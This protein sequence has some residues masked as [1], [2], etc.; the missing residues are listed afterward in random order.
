MPRS[1][2]PLYASEN[3]AVRSIAFEPSW[4][5][6]QEVAVGLSGLNCTAVNY[7]SSSIPCTVSVTLTY[8][9]TP[10]NILSPM[11]WTV[12]STTAVTY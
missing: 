11:T 3:K 6:S 10:G 5:M 1:T 12:T 8:T 4:P 9:W 7:S 2:A